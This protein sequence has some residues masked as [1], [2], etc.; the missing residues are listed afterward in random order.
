MV[1]NPT[2]S[3]NQ[4]ALS[5]VQA[6]PVLVLPANADLQL[7]AASETTAEK[8]LNGDEDDD[9]DGEMKSP[10]DLKSPESPLSIFEKRTMVQLEDGT[11]AQV[12]QGHS[13]QGHSS[14]L[15]RYL[16]NVP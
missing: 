11:M 5:M 14:H 3:T 8:K 15:C 12:S 4:N 1:R 9:E 2:V 16:R 7:S 13:S 10:R 6:S